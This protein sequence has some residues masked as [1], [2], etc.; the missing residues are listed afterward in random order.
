MK[1]SPV[2]DPSLAKKV[3]Y[4]SLTILLSYILSNCEEEEV[5]SFEGFQQEG[6][7]LVEEEFDLRRRRDI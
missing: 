3:K 4:P 5:C 7:P 2:L 6:A 1:D